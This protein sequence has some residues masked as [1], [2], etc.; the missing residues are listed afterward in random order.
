MQGFYCN[1][2]YYAQLTQ[3]NHQRPP[4]RDVKRHQSGMAPGSPLP[5]RPVPGYPQDAHQ[6]GPPRQPGNRDQGHHR[7][8]NPK[9]ETLQGLQPRQCSR[10]PDAGYQT[11]CRPA[12]QAHKSEL[13]QN[14][15]FIC[16]CLIMIP[17]KEGRPRRPPFL[18]LFYYMY[19]LQFL[20]RIRRF[21]EINGCHSQA[22]VVC[23]L[24]HK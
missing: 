9:A 19:F 3:H 11:R 12:L 18:G 10:Q 7:R 20:G 24:F 14:G 16:R 6:T 2:L 4:I 1:L 5:L 23:L 21:T 17:L 8:R 22:A 13:L 15:Q